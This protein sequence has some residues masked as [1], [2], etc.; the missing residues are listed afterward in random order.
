MKIGLTGNFSG[1]CLIN[2]DDLVNPDKLDLILKKSS[3]SFGENMPSGINNRMK[4]V[5]GNSAI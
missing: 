5:I 3:N 2:K 1:F 4:I